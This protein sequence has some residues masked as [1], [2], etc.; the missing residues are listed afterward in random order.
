MKK[1][2]LFQILSVGIVVL[3]A[4]LILWA[5]QKEKYPNDIDARIAA[6][7]E[8]EAYIVAGYELQAARN[9][10]QQELNKID[11]SKLE[12]V[13]EAD[14]RLVM[15]L[16]TDQAFS[17]ETKLKK[18]NV[19][20]GVLQSRFP[21]LSAFSLLRSEK[22]I[23]SCIENSVTVS[24][25]LLNLG[26]DISLPTKRPGGPE[27]FE[28]GMLFLENWVRNPNYVEAMMVVYRDGSSAI[29]VDPRNTSTQSHITLER[30]NGLYYYR[31]GGSDSPIL[32]LAHTHQSGPRPSAE[33]LIEMKKYPGLIGAVYYDGTLTA[34]DA[35]GL[36]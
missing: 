16:P 9:E 8:M 22:I 13:R 18:L 1:Q 12:F 19:T 31:E 4:C 21:E 32:F 17:F 35:S 14:G 29:Y 28:D 7:P 24:S 36:L 34:Y 33:D 15:H 3:T 6:S 10:I 2:L 5:C 25:T 27:G 30:T 23:T 26:F 11:F 20:K